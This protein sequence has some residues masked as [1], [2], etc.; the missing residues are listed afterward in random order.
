MTEVNQVPIHCETCQKSF[1]YTIY[2]NVNVT[3]T[4][5]LK[6]KLIN[7]TVF[8]CTCPHCEQKYF[9]PYILNYQDMD[10]KILIHFFPKE[11]EMQ[12][13]LQQVLIDDQTTNQD[14]LDSGYAV[15]YVGSCDEF[16]EKLCIAEEG[17]DDRII[18]I[19]K[20]YCVDRMLQK[21]IVFDRILFSNQQEVGVGIY[22]VNGKQI[23][24]FIPVSEELLKIAEKQLEKAKPEKDLLVDRYWAQIV[25]SVGEE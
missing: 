13:E 22:I 3:E 14:F 11:E 19:V 15:R 8:Q 12:K 18:E 25:A 23:S 4:P 9:I 6:E 17:Y 10:K 5:E 2:Q 20:Y 24:H 1:D 7:Q 16:F 21:N